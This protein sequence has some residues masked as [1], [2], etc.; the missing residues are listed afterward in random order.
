WAQ[1]TNLNFAVI[2]DDGVP[3]GA[4]DDQQGDPGQGDIRIGGF[5]FGSDDL[6]GAWF[7]PPANNYSAAGDLFLNTAQP[8]NIAS[9]YDLFT[10]AVHELGHALG[11]LHSTDYYAAM[12]PTYVGAKSSNLEPD[13]IAGIR[14]LYSADAA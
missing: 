8:F 9:T 11:L 2:P 13:D 7:P 10:V 3:L 6:G 4:G 14:S 1:Y 12:Y 5:D